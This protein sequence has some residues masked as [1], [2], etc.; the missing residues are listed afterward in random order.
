MHTIFDGIVLLF[1]PRKGWQ[2]IA[3]HNAGIVKLLGLH[4]IPSALIPAVC[5][6]Y[7][8][9]EVGWTI[10]EDMV[11]LTKAT[12]APMCIM[13]FLAMLAGVLFMGSLVNWMSESYTEGDDGNASFSDGVRLITYTATP[14]F[15]AGF[16][17][18][19]PILWLDIILGVGVACYCIFLLYIGVCPIMRVTETQAFLYASAVF[20][21]ALVAFVGLLTVTILLWDFGMFPEYT[22]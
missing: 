9:T 7:G 21:I 16:M 20:A 6:Y 11:K 15:V 12:A 10:G 19:Q 4:L 17:G 5:W 8:V 1:N 18:L 3:S 2:L 22:Y 14:F 13:F